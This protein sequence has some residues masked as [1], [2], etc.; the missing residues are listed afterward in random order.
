[1]PC[2]LPKISTYIAFPKKDV[3]AFCV[4]ALEISSNPVENT[5]DIFTALGNAVLCFLKISL[6]LYPQATHFVGSSRDV[7]YVGVLE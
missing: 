7:I 4:R 6:K 5:I 1:M 3:L 2:C